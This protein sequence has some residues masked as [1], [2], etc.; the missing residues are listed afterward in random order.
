VTIEALVGV[1]P[2]GDAQA[3]ESF[4]LVGGPARTPRTSPRSSA[5]TPWST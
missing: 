3:V 2:L 5:A 4:A 1:V